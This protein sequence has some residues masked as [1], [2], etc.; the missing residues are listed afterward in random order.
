MV[1][2]LL[3]P[4]IGGFLWLIVANLL[5]MI[6]S[7]DGHRARAVFLIAVGIPLLAWIVW[8]SGPLVALGFLAAALSI[9]RWPALMLLR[10]IRRSLPGLS[11]PA[12]D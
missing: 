4:V 5:G 7:S 10:R 12:A 9:L 11:A 6:P 2:S 3:T 8:E 1:M